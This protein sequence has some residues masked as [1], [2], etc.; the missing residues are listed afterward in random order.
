MCTI[1]GAV[2]ILGFWI[3]ATFFSVVGSLLLTISAAN[4]IFAGIAGVYWLGRW[5]RNVYYSGIIHGTKLFGTEIC[6][7]IMSKGQTVLSLVLED[8]NPPSAQPILRR[9]T[10]TP[11]YNSWLPVIVEEK[12][13]FENFEDENIIQKLGIPQCA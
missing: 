5:V 12:A 7:D 9:K 2:A 13:N 4:V 6:D 11:N 10:S 1:A 8:S 3:A